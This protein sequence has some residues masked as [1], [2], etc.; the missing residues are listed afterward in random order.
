[1]HL[2]KLDNGNPVLTRFL[3]G[4]IPS[5]AILSHRWEADDQEVTFKDLTNGIGLNKLGYGKIRFCGEQARRDGLQYFWVDSCC[6][7]KANYA[8]LQYALNSMFCWYRN[9]T[10][11]YVYLSD[12]HSP[13]FGN[14][15]AFN[16]QS[17]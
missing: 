15:A 13:P 8:E 5:Y 3:A 2:L 12:V 10:R 6:I 7:D 4:N 9:A 14:N 11:C 1:M 16:L 17:W